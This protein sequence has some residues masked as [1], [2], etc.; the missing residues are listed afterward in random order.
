MHIQL[1]DATRVEL[2][3]GSSGKNLAEKLKKTAPHEALAMEVNNIPR[4][5]SHV[6]KEGDIV[7]L[8]DFDDR[9]GKELFW[10]SSAHVLAQA[11]LRL[12]PNALPT[13]GPP[14]EEGF[15]YDFANLTISEEDF[16]K[17]EEEMK[18][19]LKENPTPQRIEY[20][21]KKEA[22]ATFSSNKYKMEL[23]QQFEEGSLCSA[24]RQGEFLDLCRGPHLSSLSKIKALKLT[25]TSGAYWRGDSKNEMLTRIY[26]ITFPDRQ[27][28]KEYLD[29]IEEA[30]RRDHKLL[31]PRLDLFSLHEEAAG[32]PFFHPHGM[33]IWHTL[34]N[35]LRNMLLKA[36]YEEIKTPLIM[37]RSLWETS[38]H[39]Q[40][41]RENMF[42]IQI[43][44]RD[45]AIKPMNCPGA[46]L[47][48]AS[49]SHSY[50][51]LPCR[52]AELGHV[53]RYEPSGS[54]SGLFRVRG[55]HQDDAH[56]FLAPQQ[57]EEEIVKVLETADFLCKTFDLSYRL[58][59]ST[60]P[61]TGTIGTDEDWEASTKGLQEALERNGK[62][63]KLN[64]GDGA[65]YGPKIDLHVKDALGRTWQ[66]G[67]IQ[68]DMA[69][70][71]RFKLEYT[72]ADGSR[73]QPIMIHRALFGSVER[74]LGILIEHFAGRFPLWISPRQLRVL[75]VADRHIPFAKEVK[76]VFDEAEFYIDVD[77]SSESIG[78]KVR[79]AQLDQV[80]YILTVGDQELESKTVS[81]RTRDNF[82]YGSIDL[83]TLKATLL[84]EKAT[85]ALH[86][87]FKKEG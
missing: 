77:D 13:I 81:L 21:S 73:K 30:K 61:E 26:G 78:K 17:I 1:K 34:T 47:Y 16:P 25:K 56:I 80:N 2:E 14:I 38:G 86:S 12:W 83:E 72:D 9:K 28:L 87:P 52:V 48:F 37:N 76:Q 7:E 62:P 43:E 46:C 55:F 6:L 4:D 18:K 19:I 11:V 70:P 36:D 33:R 27:L 57:I 54:L 60:R 67:T 40:N 10:H 63:Y 82:V 68:L 74:F 15:Y 53:H 41:Y 22:L 45:F 84:K 39:W 24:Y 35:F 31:G 5:L 29:R 44:E 75:T 32:M 49:R 50:R 65:F 23:I 69:L 58:E 8:F 79:Q 51:D 66:C 42:T 3:E 59:L 71:Q 20:P 64:P 85:R